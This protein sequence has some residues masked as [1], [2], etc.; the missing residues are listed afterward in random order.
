[1][2][3]TENTTTKQEK[4]EALLDL[5]ALFKHI[6]CKVQE[7]RDSGKVIF[8]EQDEILNC[9][10]YAKI[11]DIKVVILGQDPYPT[12]GNA[13]GFSFSVKEGVKI[14]ASL[15]NIYKELASDLNVPIPNSGN[16]EGWARQGVILLNRILT[17]EQ[18]RP[19]SHAELGWELF[20]DKLIK[21]IS[22]KTTSTVFILWGTDA[23][24]TAHLIDSTKHLILKS[25]HP[26][27]MSASKGF[28]GS[29]PF[30]KTNNYLVANGKD[31]IKW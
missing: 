7:L 26:S 3:V 23:Q 10:K 11:E 28:F 13:H 14:P 25:P 22:D 30:S 5:R 2:E 15:R 18:G 19:R 21:Y 4:D 17:V 12:P 24:A 6:K 9:F 20:T 29:K 31:P 16:L 27:P 8:P 1:M